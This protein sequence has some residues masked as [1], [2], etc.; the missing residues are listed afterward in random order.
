M[1]SIKRG[2]RHLLDTKCYNYD[3]KADESRIKKIERSLTDAVKNA[4]KVLKTIKKEIDEAEK[5][6]SRK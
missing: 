6:K 3:T 4:R 5:M 2:F 1:Y